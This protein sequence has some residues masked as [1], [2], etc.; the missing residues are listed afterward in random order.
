MIRRRSSTRR[1]GAARLAP[2]RR[3]LRACRR[4]GW[5]RPARHPVA[6]YV[7]SYVPWAFVENHQIVA[8]S[9]ARLAAGHTRT[10]ARSTSP[11][12]HVRL[13]QQ[14]DRGAPGLVAVVGLAVRPQARVVLRGGLRRRHL[15]LDLRRRQPRGLVAGRAGAGVRRLAGVPAPERG[16]GPDRDRVRVPVDLLGAHRPRRVP[17][18]LLHGAAVRVPGPRL[19]PRRAVARDVAP[20]SGCWPGCR[21]RRRARAV[22]AVAAPPAAVRDRPGERDRRRTR[23]P[24][25]PS[26]RTSRSPPRAVAHRGRRS[27]IGVLLLVRE[28]LSLT[29]EDDADRL[30]AERRPAAGAPR[31]RGSGSAAAGRARP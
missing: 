1:R 3:R 11:D 12:R 20:T 26:S 16:A 10:D 7:V 24:A 9:P 21:R 30:A 23:R 14:P 6:L 15:R 19:L 8:A 22:R 28:L 29:D 31:W 5:R 4:S 18:P 13:P 27:G 25:R 2:P 17:V